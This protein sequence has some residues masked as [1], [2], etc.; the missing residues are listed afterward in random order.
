MNRLKVKK[1]KKNVTEDQNDAIKIYFRVP[2]AGIKGEQL[3][4]SCI[5][6]MRRFLKKNVIF[7]TLYDTKKISQ[8]C[9]TKDRI[10]E[11]QRHNVIYELTCPGC[12]G[13]YVGKTDAC[14]ES[15]ITQHCTKSDQ[16]MHQH[17]SKCN[18]FKEMYKF[19]NIENHE[20][21]EKDVPPTQYMLT[22][23]MSNYRILYCNRNWSQLLFL[24]AYVIK[25]QK[26]SLNTGL[27]ASR[28]LVLFA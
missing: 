25:T 3:V 7:V 26:P 11:T 23:G 19:L 10:P 15:R 4:K 20:N 18:E 13:K 1:K 8:F 5:R 6:K 24:E 9:N 12:A 14:I 16:P 28:E 27:K 2:Y 21:T 22:C 17:F